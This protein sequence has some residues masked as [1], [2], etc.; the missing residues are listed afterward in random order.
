MDVI[1]ALKDKDKNLRVSNG[2]K[3]LVWDETKPAW[4][5]Y[6]RPRRARKTR[7]EM[8]TIYEIEAV[9]ALVA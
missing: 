5:V 7:V 9:N 1:K 2:E 8:T 4:V 6:S 3:W